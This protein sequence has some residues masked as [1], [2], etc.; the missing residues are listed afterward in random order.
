VKLEGEAIPLGELVELALVNGELDGL[1]LVETSGWF[2]IPRRAAVIEVDV[3]VV[4]GFLITD[5]LLVTVLFVVHEDTYEFPLEEP[6]L[7]KVSR[8]AVR[9]ELT[10]PECDPVV[11]VEVQRQI[12]TQIQQQYEPAASDL[13]APLSSR[14]R[15]KRDRHATGVDVPAS[16][17]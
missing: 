8:S 17:R 15:H 9:V 7:T 4:I 2:L 3:A 13:V 16:A 11:R 12:V 10:C 5:L 1:V 14:M 6:N